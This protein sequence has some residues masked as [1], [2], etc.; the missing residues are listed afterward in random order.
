MEQF[1]Y[2]LLAAPFLLGAALIY[3]RRRDLRAPIL[4]VGLLGGIAGVLAELWYFA[5]YWQ[6]MT[7]LGKGVISIEDFLAGAGIAA[8]S[9]VLYPA[10]TKTSVPHVSRRGWR[11]LLVLFLVGLAAM[12]GG[13]YGFGWNSVAVSM[14]VMFLLAVFMIIR[15][16][17]LLRQAVVT[18][19]AFVVL[20][21]VTYFV[22][23]GVLSPGYLGAHFLLTGHPLNP[24]LFGFYPLLEVWWYFSWGVFAPTLVGFLGARSTKNGLVDPVP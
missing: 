2:M 18:G 13:M 24:T 12:L 9:V 20:G 8:L 11:G 10:F 17:S 1:I 5:D 19:A 22:L 4:K 14:T 6:P 3:W 23:F 15:R 16:P 21:G 7:L